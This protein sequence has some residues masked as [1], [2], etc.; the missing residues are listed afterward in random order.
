MPALEPRRLA[1][2]HTSLVARA[3]DRLGIFTLDDALDAGLSRGALT[4][5]CAHGRYQRILPRTFRLPGPPLSWRQRVMAVTVW[6][7]GFASHETAGNLYG[8]EGC[9]RSVIHVTVP[10]P[11]R[12][13]GSGVKLHVSSHLPPADITFLGPIRT[14]SA[15]R[16]L[17]DLGSILDEERVEI[18]LEDALRRR[19]V[20]VPRLRWQLQQYARS[21]RNGAGSLARL[22]QKRADARA[23]ESVLE[24]KMARWFRRTKLPPPVRQHPILERGKELLRIDFAYP[25]AR[26]AI[27]GLSYR[28]H[29]GRKS[30]LRDRDRERILKKRHWRWLYVVEEDV[31]ERPAEL[32]REVARLLGIGLPFA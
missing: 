17:A 7:E 28:W 1:D 3:S 23:A 14:T 32:E 2:A 13:P 5:A 15:A 30:W 20:T 27:E 31:D 29:S 9:G 4:R 12:S 25:D 10:G 18:A 11:R 16:T 21:G 24:V 22:V 19:L 6:C 26:L 8:L